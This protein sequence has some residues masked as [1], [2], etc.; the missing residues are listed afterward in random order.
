M[1]RVREKRRRGVIGEKDFFLTTRQSDAIFVFPF[2]FYRAKV[3]C[4]L[5]TQAMD[6]KLAAILAKILR[7]LQISAYIYISGSLWKVLYAGI[8]FLSAMLDYLEKCGERDCFKMAQQGFL[9]LN[10][11]SAPTY[12]LSAYI[13][14]WK[15]GNFQWKEW[16][17]YFGLF[18][19]SYLGV[20]L[21]AP[22]GEE[23]YSLLTIFELFVIYICTIPPV[24][25]YVLMP[26]D[27]VEVEQV[28]VEIGQFNKR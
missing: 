22:P 24:V 28:D 14:P 23:N 25:D 19:S 2:S 1:F 26:D 18:W 10:C 17:A 12:I 27:V 20:I 3:G 11:I 15:S 9:I 8:I 21:S 6:P 5:F 16:I 7:L 4:N 13:R